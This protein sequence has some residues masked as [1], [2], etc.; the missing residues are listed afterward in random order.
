MAIRC[1]KRTKSAFNGFNNDRKVL[2]TNL[3]HKTGYRP[4]LHRGLGCR[5][6][7]LAKRKRRVEAPQIQVAKA[8]IRQDRAQPFFVGECERAR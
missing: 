8:R 6:R 7:R 3:A 4:D 2:N 1:R 5:A